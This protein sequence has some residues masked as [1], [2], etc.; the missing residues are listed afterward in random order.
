[1][2]KLNQE[3][4]TN[5]VLPIPPLDEQHRI[6]KKVDELMVLCDHLK[7]RLTQAR[8]TRC[9]LAGAVVEGALN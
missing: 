3:S 8:N 7:Q 1:M 2:P 4:L 9:Q 5:F 6:V